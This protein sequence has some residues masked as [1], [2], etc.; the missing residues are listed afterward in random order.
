MSSD[1]TTAA[2]TSTSEL[3]ESPDEWCIH[4]FFPEPRITAVPRLRAILGRAETCDTP[5]EGTRVSRQH[6]ELRREGRFLVLQDLESRNGTFVDARRITREPLAVGSVV[7][8]GDWVGAVA[9]LPA[10]GGTG[11]G[12]RR[13]APGLLGGP[14]LA[15]L[16]APTERA[17]R[18][19]LPIVI[20]GE[21]GTGK[22]RV[23]RAI[24]EWS[25]RSGPFVAVNCAALPENLAEAELF[26]YRKGAFTSA[27]R[28]SD[29]YFRT[30]HQGT[31]LLDEIADLPLPLQ[32]KLLRVLEEREVTPLGETR[33]IKVDVRVLSATQTPLRELVERGRMRADLCARLDGMTLQLPPL[34]ERLDEIPTLF[35]WFLADAAGGSA[36]NDTRLPPASGLLNTRLVEQLAIYRWPFNVR[37]LALVARGLLA[38]HTGD[39][40]FAV[41]DL[42]A[43]LAE[44]VA[45]PREALALDTHGP[46]S[47]PADADRAPRD[48]EARSELLL[49]ALRE[50]RGNLARAA[51]Q[52]GLS[53]QSAYRLLER[54]PGLDL[55]AL[56]RGGGGHE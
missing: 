21:T 7:R 39:E 10:L 56:R 5:L 36:P 52:V 30:A 54:V 33:P 45:P 27:E 15:A 12:V 34:R 32:A 37:E 26:G 43:R 11:I 6:A 41:K 46:D 31:L 23:A 16:L 55:E 50:H 14:R 44:A 22:E 38:V 20:C 3:R 2:G 25:G 29:G 1:L 40:S 49:A 17:A 24:H 9:R 19:L 53:R 18:T 28:A 48:A 8:V 42:P 51:A 13:L 35:E 47:P 4:W